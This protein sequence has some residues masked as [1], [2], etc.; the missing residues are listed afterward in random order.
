MMFA[1]VFERFPGLRIGVIEFELSWAPYFI[2]QMDRKYEEH[3]LRQG[4]PL[5]GGV[6]AE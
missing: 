6:V 1:G 5:Q 2:Q 3:R 4:D